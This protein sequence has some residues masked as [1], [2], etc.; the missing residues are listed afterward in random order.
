MMYFLQDPMKKNRQEKIE[1][2]PLPSKA[3]QDKKAVTKRKAFPQISVTIS[4]FSIPPKFFIL[5]LSGKKGV[6]A[7]TSSGLPPTPF[8]KHASVKKVKL[9]C[10][11]HLIPG[12]SQI[13]RREPHGP[14]P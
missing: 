1:S 13:D 12:Q 10:P 3:Q 4:F 5:F 11:L 9:I 8:P 7:K 2:P 14:F 6:F